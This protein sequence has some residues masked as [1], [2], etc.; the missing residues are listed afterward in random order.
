MSEKV[1]LL[2]L[3][4]LSDF[5]Q[6]FNKAASLPE[7]FILRSLRFAATQLV[8]EDDR[9]FVCQLFE[10]FK[11]I[12]RRARAAVKC[13]QWNTV[14]RIHDLVPHQAASHANISFLCVCN[15]LGHVYAGLS[16]RSL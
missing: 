8:I 3:E 16:R 2:Q 11:V 15:L 5:A 7:T 6:F 4:R 10:W 12:M 14:T 9:S 1:D 13:E